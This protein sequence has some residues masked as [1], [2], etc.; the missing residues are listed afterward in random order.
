MDCGWD[1]PCTRPCEIAQPILRFVWIMIIKIIMKW[2]IRR[3]QCSYDSQCLLSQW[4]SSQAW[5]ARGTWTAKCYWTVQ[6]LLISCSSLASLQIRDPG[7]SAWVVCLL[8]DQSFNTTSQPKNMPKLNALCPFEV[9]YADC[10]FGAL[11]H[12]SLSSHISQ[13][14]STTRQYSKGACDL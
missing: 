2:R 1:E 7:T 8:F 13:A 12:S 9:L 14:H 3:W 6:L 11:K 5:Q 10:A 4:A